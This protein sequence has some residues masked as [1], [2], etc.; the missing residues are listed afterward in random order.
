MANNPTEKENNE[1]EEI[2]ETEYVTRSELSEAIENALKK[3]M[4][5]SVE[6][7]TSD[8]AGFD[9]D[10]ENV[11][12][13]NFSA[14]DIERIAEEKVQQ[15]LAKLTARRTAAQPAKKTTAVKKAAPKKEPEVEPTQPGKTSWSKKLWG[16]E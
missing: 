7:P 11:E 16:T 12:P 6:I 5:E 1:V 15:A 9:T 14:G 13:I 8:E 2:D 10:P 3:L 4:G